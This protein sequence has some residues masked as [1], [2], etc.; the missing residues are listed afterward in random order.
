M[1]NGTP[2]IE[3]EDIEMTNRSKE[4]TFGYYESL[5]HLV[6]TTPQIVPTKIANTTQ[7]SLNIASLASVESNRQTSVENIP[8]TYELVYTNAE[9]RAKELDD[10]M[11]TLFAFNT[12]EE[13][14]DYIR[15][16]LGLDEDDDDPEEIAG[17]T[18]ADLIEAGAELLTDQ[19]SG[20]R[21]KREKNNV[22]KD[23]KNKSKKNSKKNLKNSKNSKNK[24]KK[25]SKN[26]K[27]SKQSKKSKSQRK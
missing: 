25:N 8:E 13:R 27:N 17:L 7:I 3:E 15:E 16:V 10:N 14:I 1:R 2:N 11:R 26:S 12:D 9:K 23:S 6:A 5:E 20:G 24:S 19:M 18:D 21:E 22:K 4:P